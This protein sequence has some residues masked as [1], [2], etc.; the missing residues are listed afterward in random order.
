MFN[1]FPLLSHRQGQSPHLQEN[2]TGWCHALASA[3]RSFSSSSVG[4]IEVDNFCPSESVPLLVRDGNSKSDPASHHLLAA[5]LLDQ[6][7]DISGGNAHTV[8]NRMVIF[9]ELCAYL[10][11][12]ITFCFL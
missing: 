11:M 8:A 7:A 10:G 2:W 4:L 9:R 1:E 12:A 6:L 5:G 3:I